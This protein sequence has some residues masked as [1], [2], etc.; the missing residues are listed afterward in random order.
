MLIPFIV[1]A[2]GY[3]G[4]RIYMLKW[5]FFLSSY[6]LAPT[7]NWE[8]V[9][10]LPNRFLTILGWQHHWQ[11]FILLTVVFVYLISQF[12]VIFHP[13][14]NTYRNIRNNN[15]HSNGNL[16][17]FKNKWLAF[18]VGCLLLWLVVIFL[19][20]VPV[21]SILDSRY[22]FLPYFV[23]TLLLATT[24]QWLINHHWHYLALVLALSVL[25]VGIK[26]VESG[27]AIIQQPEIIKQHRLEGQLILT[28]SRSEGVLFNPISNDWYYD[29]LQWLRKHTL[30]LPSGI[31]LC[32]D[33]CVCQPSEPIYQ[34]Q[35]GKLVTFQL[36]QLNQVCDYRTDVDLTV[37]FT[38]AQ[39]LVNWQ[40]GPYQQGEYYITFNEQAIMDGGWFFD[41]KP[42]TL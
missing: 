4:W 10:A 27:V 19:P 22:L 33:L 26:S 37:N 29:S 7:L 24:L 16:G 34:Y 1:V 21:L 11:W 6:M 31:K 18:T 15:L 20:I 8:I 41:T 42:R 23:F 35:S 5:Q 38:F 30:K 13:A 25:A 32:Y 2:V 9:L 12:H 14:K 40:L 17:L 36:S 39:D 3:V 28:D